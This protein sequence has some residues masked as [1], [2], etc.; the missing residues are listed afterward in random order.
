MSVYEPQTGRTE[1]EKQEFVDTL[2]ERL[3]GTVELKLML[4]LAGDFN[5][6]VRVVELGEEEVVDILRWGTRNVV[7]IWW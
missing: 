5:V 3:M 7:K 1:T 4:C 6:H 2:T